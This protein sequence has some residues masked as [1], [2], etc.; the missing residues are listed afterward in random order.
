M[1]KKP[2]S[3]NKIY[4]GNCG[5]AGHIYRN[6]RQPITSFGI[7]LLKYKPNESLFDIWNNCIPP[8]FIIG[9]KVIAI[10]I[11]PIPPNHCRIALHSKI[12]FG[13]SLRFEIM[14]D[15]VVV[16]P[17]ILSKKALVKEKSRSEKM[18][19]NEPN[20]AIL[21]QDNAV[22]KNACCKF[23]FLFWSKFESK[24]VWL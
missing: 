12:P 22:N 10:I 4:C 11:I 21:N 13:I 19:G 1:W 3:R 23:N 7:I 20:I 8:T 9:I 24:K 17:D 15:P 2:T 6:C 5:E 14:V 18:K 16:I